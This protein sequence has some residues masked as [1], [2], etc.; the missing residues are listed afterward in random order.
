MTISSSTNRNDYTG[1]G[2][3][4]TYSYTFKINA[5][6]EL[7]VTKRDTSN[8][9]TALALTTDYT[10]TGVGL[11]AGGAITLVAGNLTTG[12]ILTI[13]RNRPF[14]QTAS[15]R[16][17][18]AFFASSHEDVFDGLTMN[19]QELFEKADRSVKLS[20]TYSSATFNPTLPSAINTPNVTLA[21][22]S[23]G[24]GLAIGPSIASISSAQ[25]YASAAAASAAAAAGA[26]A[27]AVADV[28]IY[29]LLQPYL[30]LNVG[31]QAT[32]SANTL[33]IS[34]YQADGASRPVGLGSG[35][36]SISFRDPTN[37]THAAYTARQTPNTTP[38][39]LLTVPNG[40]TLGHANGVAHDIF[41]YAIDNSGTVEIAVCS[42][43]IFEDGSLQNTTAITTAADLDNVLYSGTART[44]VAIRLIGKIRS[45]QATAGVWATSPS[46]TKVGFFFL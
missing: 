19:D 28:A 32:V 8:V 33:L 20:D 7:L 23:S 18:T 22:N 40:A 21:T 46:E 44:A 41:V 35:S 25:S 1:D 10:V 24:N 11:S 9:E 12:Y 43:K 6:T 39:G 16:N 14:T 29:L 31:F 34:F 26:A 38:Y 42:T 17:Q 4:A 36:G 5:N 15:I 37:A 13:K 3:T 2:T 45:T 27:V 30:I